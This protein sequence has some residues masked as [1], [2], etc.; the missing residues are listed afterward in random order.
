MHN[1]GFNGANLTNATA[2]RGLS[3][4]R[5]THV[6]NR[7]LWVRRGHRYADGA[8]TTAVPQATTSARALPISEESKRIAITALA[9]SS[10][11]FS[12]IRSIACLRA[13]SRT[14]VN[15][16]TSPGAAMISRR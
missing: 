11:A 14:T 8:A 13:S 1:A 10:F 12:I 4:G 16:E 7:L 15:C 3:A 9:P 5:Q 6:P 2:D